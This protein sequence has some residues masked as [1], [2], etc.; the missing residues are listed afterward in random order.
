[1]KILGLSC[2]YHDSAAC[3]I[4]NGQIIAAGAEERFS[5]KKHDNNFPKLAIDYCLQKSGLAIN[6]L[7]TDD[8]SKS[9]V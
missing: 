3:I 7:D 6:E 8:N 2:F 1:M 5:R 4:I 9:N